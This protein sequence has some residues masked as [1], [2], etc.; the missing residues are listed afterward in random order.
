LSKEANPR[1]KSA[2]R[3]GIEVGDLVEYITPRITGGRGK[4]RK[5]GLVAK[6]I[7]PNTY[8]NEYCDVLASGGV[9]L[10]IESRRLQKVT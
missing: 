5:V 4:G 10:T 8:E 2:V 9:I 6:V 3:V 7:P 1:G